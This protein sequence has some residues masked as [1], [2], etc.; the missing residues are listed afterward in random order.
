MRLAEKTVELTLCCQLGWLFH[1]WPWH[2]IPLGPS[3]PFW[4]GLTQKQ[5]ARAGFDAAM[6]L[7]N[8]RILLL[9]FKAGRRLAKGNVR[10]DAPHAQLSALQNR[11]G[12]QHRLIYY[13]LPEITRTSEL[14]GAPW[15]LERTW[16]LDVASIPRLKRPRRRSMSHYMTLSPPSGIVKITSEPVEVEAVNWRY[17]QA[18]VSPLTLGGHY[19]T[20]EKF[21]SYAIKIRQR[22]VGAVLPSADIEKSD[23]Q[24][25]ITE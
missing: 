7:S 8:A 13:V 14:H 12:A 23:L 22:G 24:H 6:K 10:F 5:E 3:Q 15:L 4:F 18:N 17:I 9:Q 25:E 21:W 16:F 20:F 19:E 2:P 11:L 1:P